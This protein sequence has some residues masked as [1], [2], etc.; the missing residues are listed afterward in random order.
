AMGIEPVLVAH[1]RDTIADIKAVFAKAMKSA[2]VVITVGGVSVG[3][4][5]FV[6]D[7]LAA[8]RVQ[9]VFW[10]VAMKPGKPFF[11]GTLGQKLI[12]GLP[13]NPVSAMVTFETLV[14]P[15]L[16]RML[17]MTHETPMTLKAVLDSDLEKKG[18]RME[19]VRGVLTL[20]Q[21]GELA[22]SPTSGQDSHMVGGL[23]NA[24]CLILFPKDKTLM[25]KGSLADVSLLQWGA[26]G[27]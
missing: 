14:R 18:D 19:F 17:G 5:D 12:F 7:V 23:A 9:Q 27:L 1:A 8:L 3:D 16:R 10:S 6:K 13:G 24:N 20:N 4:Y 21:Y 25:T 22:V 2:D 15:A 26:E 11:F